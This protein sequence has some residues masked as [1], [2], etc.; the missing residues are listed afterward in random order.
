MNHPNRFLEVDRQI[1]GDIYTSTEAMDNLVVLCDDFGSRFGGTEGERRAAEF[2]VAKMEEYGLSNVHLEPVEYVGWIRGEANL[3]VIDPVQKAISC[4]SLPHSPPADLEGT[5][6]ELGDGAPEEFERRA[7]EIPGRIVMVNSVV[8]PLG[9]RRW[10]HRGEKYGRS[11][12]AGAAGFLFV[13]HYPGYGP[14]TGGVGHD[15]EG[16][17]PGFSIAH[18]DGA[19]LRRLMKRHGEVQL[20]LTSTDRSEPMTSWNIIG[21]LPGTE[22]PEEVIMLGCHYDGHDIAQGADD[23][24]SGAVAV[25]EAARVLA[26]YAP[27]LPRPVRFVLWGVEEIGLLGSRAYVA[28]HGDE[29][30]QIRFYLNMDSAGSTTNKRDVVLNEWPELAPLF[31]GW[32]EEMAHDYVI[33]QSVMAFSDHFPFFLAGVPTGGM[34]SAEPPAGRGYGHTRYDTVDKVELK[35]LREASTLAARLALRVAHAEDWPAGRRSEEAVQA[36][37]DTPEYQE[38]QEYREKLDAF[39]QQARK[40]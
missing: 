6:I 7:A 20:R 30:S 8:R 26:Q 23:P 34:Q 13:N 29:L 40:G 5:I 21:D 33:A 2:F 28:A 38:E 14:A 18:E 19:F 22:H 10:I 32:G 39:Y 35:G 4:I 11:L 24:A 31:V 1:V 37:L 15:G 27:D 25:L 12:M 17:I 9:T 16:L 36:L 3:E